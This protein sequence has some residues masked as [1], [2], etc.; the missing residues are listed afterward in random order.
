MRSIFAKLLSGVLALRF[1]LWTPL[2]LPLAG[3][4]PSLSVWTLLNCV[5]SHMLKL[6]ELCCSPTPWQLPR[7]WWWWYEHTSKC[8]DLNARAIPSR[9]RALLIINHSVQVANR[10]R[11]LS[12]DQS[13]DWA[14]WTNARREMTMPTTI[15]WSMA[16]NG[17]GI[18]KHEGDPFREEHH[19]YC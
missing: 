3:P 8:L 12:F 6:S 11:E 5:P 14:R 2:T 7:W 4:P 9:P 18:K 17:V 13:D 15:I 19:V 16:N 10:R 1:R